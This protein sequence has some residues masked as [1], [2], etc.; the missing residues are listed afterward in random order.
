VILQVSV[1]PCTDNICIEYKEHPTRSICIPKY[2]KALVKL[3]LQFSA[4]VWGEPCKF[5][6]FG[7]KVNVYFLTLGYV[8][9][10]KKHLNW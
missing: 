6:T 2:K 9:T 4:P 8:F 7:I 1:L 3:S 5:L 10:A